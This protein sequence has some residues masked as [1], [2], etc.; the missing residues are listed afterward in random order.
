MLAGRFGSTKDDSIVHQMGKAG[1]HIFDFL[2]MK[3]VVGWLSKKIV[4]S[5]RVVVAIVVDLMSVALGAEVGGHKQWQIV[6]ARR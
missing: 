4:V 5:S 2:L 1:V 3:V 6:E